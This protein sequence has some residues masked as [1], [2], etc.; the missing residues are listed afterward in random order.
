M[1]TVEF[2]RETSSGHFVRMYR[3]NDSNYVNKRVRMVT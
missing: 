2:K 1:P 3:I